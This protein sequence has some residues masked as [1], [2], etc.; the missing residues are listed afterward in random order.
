MLNQELIFSRDPNQVIRR[1]NQ[2]KNLNQ[3]RHQCW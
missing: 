2:T 1:L 3:D